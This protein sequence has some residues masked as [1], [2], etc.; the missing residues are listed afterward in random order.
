LS[1]EPA[2]R[3][4]GNREEKDAEKELIILGFCRR[5]PFSVH[6][7][8]YR[9]PELC[10]SKE[11]RRSSAAQRGTDEFEAAIFT[12]L[13]MRFDAIGQQPNFANRATFNRGYLGL[14]GGE[15]FRVDEPGHTEPGGERY[16]DSDY[17]H[18]L[19]L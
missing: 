16:N 12:I 2:E 6:A 13:Q 15:L 7:E 17:D 9:A 8:F 11:K 14:N 3:T 18:G 1:N 10:L 19:L 5:H 4:G